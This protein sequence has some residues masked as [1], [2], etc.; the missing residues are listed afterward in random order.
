MNRKSL[1]VGLASLSLG[2]ILLAPTAFAY[3]GDPSV[4]G[5]NYTLER[6]EAMEE[7]FANQDYNAWKA[8]MGTRVRVTEV[9]TQENFS[10]FAE[11]H[12]LAQ[13]GRF[14]EA[15]QIRAELGLGTRNGSRIGRG[16]G[17]G[18]GCMR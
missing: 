8:L 3:K 12:E 10:R 15:Q 5:P 4:Q 18:M 11:A 6:H 1:L 17:S 9:V 16:R 7:A 14:E 13:E 2:A